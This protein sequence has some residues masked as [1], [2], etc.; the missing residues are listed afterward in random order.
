MT[1]T[2]KFKKV[3]IIVP[4][5]KYKHPKI[6]SVPFHN[7]SILYYTNSYVLININYQSNFNYKKNVDRLHA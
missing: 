5:K 2:N 1:V 7:K 3:N 6:K 4:L